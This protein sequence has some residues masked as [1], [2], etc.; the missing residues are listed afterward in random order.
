MLKLK[1]IYLWYSDLRKLILEDIN[2]SISHI[3]F[4]IFP[5]W[6]VLW[7]Y[8]SRE[9]RKS[10]RQMK[11]SKY[12]PTK[13]WLLHNSPKVVQITAGASWEKLWWRILLYRIVIFWLKY[14]P[15]RKDWQTLWIWPFKLQLKTFREW[16]LLNASL[17]A[18]NQIGSPI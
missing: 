4:K 8:E 5:T 3:P 9:Q 2:R 1:I 11:Q 7:C 6:V 13:F 10:A 16:K 12:L 15:L 17:N 18:C 14:F